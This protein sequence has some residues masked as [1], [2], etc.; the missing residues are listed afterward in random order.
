MRFFRLPILSF[1]AVLIIV[2][3]A[4]SQAAHFLV[5]DEPQPSDAIVV[6]AGETNLRPARA[7]ELLRQGVAATRVSGR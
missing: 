4:A 7:L 2:L 1:L 6:L 5:L 3:V